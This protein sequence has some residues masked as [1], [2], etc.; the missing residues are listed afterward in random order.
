MNDT[1]EYTS[2]FDGLMKLVVRLR[3]PDG[4]PWDQEQTRRSMKRYVL[5]EC[6]ELLDAIDEGDGAELVGELADV[7]FHLAFQI[8]LGVE[9]EGF[10]ETD[11]FQ[12]AIEKLIRRHPHVFG[13]E[14]ASDARE[15][16]SRWHTIKSAERPDA[17]RSILDGVPPELPALARAQALQERAAWAGFDWED[18]EGVVEKV[19]EEI[20]ELRSARDAAEKEAEFGD[21]LFSIVNLGR[22]LKLDAEGALREADARFRKRFALMEKA[23]R[24]MGA[25]FRDMSPAEKE[26]LWQEA[27][28]LTD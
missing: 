13:D 3:G 27:K 17:D 23:S 5:E 21:L 4:C 28:R 19:A 9:E 16:E 1:A 10:T 25:D 14:V 18:I 8:H 7:M 24:D 22:W 26:R 20:S 15:V 6:Y 11:V 12:A 2:T